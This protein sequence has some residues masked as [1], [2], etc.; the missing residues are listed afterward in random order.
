MFTIALI[1]D[2]AIDDLKA[3]MI[4]DPYSVPPERL[5][6]PDALKLATFEVPTIQLCRPDRP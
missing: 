5:T 3:E 1:A 6:V 2:G 4:S